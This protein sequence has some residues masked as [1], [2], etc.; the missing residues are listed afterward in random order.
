MENELSCCCFP[1]TKSSETC[2][3][4]T[5]KARC[6]ILAVLLTI[7]SVSE[8]TANSTKPTAYLALI[9]AACFMVA[10]VMEHTGFLKCM[11]YFTAVCMVL[12]IVFLTIALL[13][14]AGVLAGSDINNNDKNAGIAI[15]VL[16]F[17]IFG[18]KLF[19]ENWQISLISGFHRQIKENRN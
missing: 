2:C 17:I 16:L 11:F 15:T 18:I 8:L 10:V 12:E 3:G 4:L 7:S 13:V 19:L 6:V 9:L 5:I 14:L 1:L